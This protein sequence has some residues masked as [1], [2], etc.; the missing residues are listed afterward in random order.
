MESQVLYDREGADL[1]RYIRALIRRWPLLLIF[2]GVAAASGLLYSGWL[3]RNPTYQATAL[4]ALEEAPIMAA[5]TGNQAPVASSAAVPTDPVQPPH[6]LQNTLL[7]AAL[8]LV[9]GAATALLLE[10]LAGG[11]QPAA[12]FPSERISVSSGSE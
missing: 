8:G 2:A 10:Y 4:V 11:R 1:R 7:A 5:D 9:V 6:R 12:T 3:E